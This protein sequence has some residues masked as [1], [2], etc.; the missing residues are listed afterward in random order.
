MRSLVMEGDIDG[1][2]TYIWPVI[3]FQD[4]LS[5]CG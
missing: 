2:Q 5:R 1:L 4:Q 3:S